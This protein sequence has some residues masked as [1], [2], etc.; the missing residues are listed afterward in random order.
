MSLFRGNNDPLKLHDKDKKG[1]ICK[2][3]ELK[4]DKNVKDWSPKSTTEVADDKDHSK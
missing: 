1:E 2:V 3:K 4:E